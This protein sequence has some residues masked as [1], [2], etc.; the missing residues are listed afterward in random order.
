MF[1]FLGVNEPKLQMKTITVSKNCEISIKF[2]YSGR[3][4]SRNVT[5]IN[6]WTFVTVLRD[7]FP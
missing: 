4:I 6:F 5:L 2:A 1:L 3:Y 7:L